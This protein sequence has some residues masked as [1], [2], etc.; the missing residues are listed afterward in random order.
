MGCAMP[1]RAT[2]N[3][4]W[5]LAVLAGAALR[6]HAITDQVLVDDEWHALHAL[7]AGGPRDVL[8][9]F[10]ASDHSIP[11]TLYDIL[12]ERTVGL[13]E[14][15]MRLPS[16]VAGI[17][18]LVVVPALLRD[19]A[20][21]RA[22]VTLA[23]L[24]AIAPLHV[25]YSRYARPYEAAMLASFVALVGLYRTTH[26]DRRWLWRAALAGAL[27]APWLLPVV[28]PLVATP[29]ALVALRAL[30]GRRD[31]RPARTTLAG[32]AL[33]LAGWLVLL[34]AP[35]LA[36][37][38]ALGAKV[39]RGSLELATLLGAS[40]LLLGTP[41]AALRVAGAARCSPAPACSCAAHRAS[42][43]GSPS[44]PQHSSRRS[45]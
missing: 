4:L 16:L 7:L 9:S 29:L 26:E 15:G 12:L 42:R 36:D 40:E 31:P 25:F 2:W 27:L 11:L 14:L 10:G 22:S 20:G 3:L 21:P 32:V 33:V 34:G 8:L 13:S 1:A 28:L 43:P 38:G 24:L 37:A 39:G 5:L 30:G 44:P 23:W 19:V 45:S 18:A 6:L 17:A 35:L 41:S